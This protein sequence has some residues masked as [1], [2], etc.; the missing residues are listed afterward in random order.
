MSLVAW[1]FRV[2]LVSVQAMSK[3]WIAEYRFAKTRAMHTQDYM[4]LAISQ[5]KRDVP[6]A[7]AKVKRIRRTPTKVVVFVERQT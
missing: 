1:G 6:T 7:T 4:T 5:A 2:Q 3:T